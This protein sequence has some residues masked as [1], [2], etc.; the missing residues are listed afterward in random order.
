MR[1]HSVFIIY[2]LLVIIEVVHQVTADESDR[3]NFK[4]PFQ[5]ISDMVLRY[6]HAFSSKM[7]SKRKNFVN[8]SESHPA[9][10][11]W[12]SGL[13]SASSD[14]KTAHVDKFYRVSYPL[15]Q[16]VRN[17]SP[18]NDEWR[19]KVHQQFRSVWSSADE[20]NKDT[21]DGNQFWPGDK[22]TGYKGLKS[23]KDSYLMAL[24]HFRLRCEMLMDP[25]DCIYSS[26]L[27]RL[28]YKY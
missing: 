4:R 12:L 2:C 28:K 5:A 21:L 7:S 24:E 17:Y 23:D 13:A 19:P 1:F 20:E 9:Q 26:H 3:W 18:H 8:L 6:R 11:P 25:Y 10:T 15:N 27:N 16:A 22:T 14:C